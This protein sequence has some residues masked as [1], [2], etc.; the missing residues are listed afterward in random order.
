[1]PGGGKKKGQ[2]LRLSASVGK[3]S[4]GRKKLTEGQIGKQRKEKEKNELY[5]ISKRDPDCP[6]GAACVPVVSWPQEKIGWTT[7][8]SYQTGL[9]FLPTLNDNQ[10]TRKVTEAARN[11]EK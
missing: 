6:V 11:E 8:H 2:T 3:H 5:V 7:Q 9:F 4:V 10:S 1:M